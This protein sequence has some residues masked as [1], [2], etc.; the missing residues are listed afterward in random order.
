[1][2]HIRVN[3]ISLHYQQAG[4]STETG[5]DVVLMH[6]VTGNLA[7][8]LFSG[9]VEQLSRDYRVTAYD[10]RGHGF[11]DAPRD[12]YTSADMAADFAAL[13]DALGLGPAV[14]VGHSYGAVIATHAAVEYPDKVHGVILSDPYFPGLRHLEPD[15]GQMH[16][17]QET[18]DMFRHADIDLGEGVNF[19]RLFEVCRDMTP[20]QRN[21]IQDAVGPAPVRWLAGL[22]KLAGTTCGRDLFD[23]AG[24][25]EE[26]LRSIRQPVVALYDEH[27]DFNQTRLWLE[28]NVPNCTIDTVSEAKHFAPLQNPAEFSRLVRQHLA[29]MTPCSALPK[30]EWR[31]E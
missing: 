30:T 10:L 1:M 11:S 2:P 7:V 18:R 24:L 23:P 29:E 14:L 31:A 5:L 6:A 27:T 8:W 28:E 25:D 4:D 26:R 3:D 13:H 15:V 16:V 17:W 21:K 12:G 22:P 9:L 19:S 20:E